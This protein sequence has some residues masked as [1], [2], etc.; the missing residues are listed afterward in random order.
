MSPSLR[1]QVKYT[2]D[3]T[4]RS[5]WINKMTLGSAL[6]VLTWSLMTA[7]CRQRL[8]TKSLRVLPR[9]NNWNKWCHTEQIR[10]RRWISPNIMLSI[11]LLNSHIKI[12]CNSKISQS[13]RDKSKYRWENHNLYM[14]SKLMIC[15]EV[16]PLEIINLWPSHLTESIKGTKQ[17]LSHQEII[18]MMPHCKEGGSSFSQIHTESENIQQ[19]PITK[20]QFRAN[21]PNILLCRIKSLQESKVLLIR[22]LMNGNSL[23][24][25]SSRKKDHL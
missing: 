11:I 21:S 8:Q 2:K 3:K 23:A 25:W 20:C 14:L 17:W 9:E 6:M 1:D 7:E 22:H 16:L 4:V 15:K 10:L 24:K 19:D 5:P 18:P 13:L 12:Q